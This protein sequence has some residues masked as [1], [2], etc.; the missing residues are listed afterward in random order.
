MRLGIQCGRDSDVPRY[1]PQVRLPE[2]SLTT[3]PKPPFFSAEKV[4]HSRVSI[5]DCSRQNC[6]DGGSMWGVAAA[7]AVITCS[8]CALFILPVASEHKVEAYIDVIK[9]VRS[10]TCNK[11]HAAVAAVFLDE[12]SLNDYEL[13]CNTDIIQILSKDFSDQNLAYS[14]IVRSDLEKHLARLR[15]DGRRICRF[16]SPYCFL[17]LS[18]HFELYDVQLERGSAPD[19]R[20]LKTISDAF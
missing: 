1:G 10:G 4:A 3:A 15:E 14:V 13:R 17:R 12:N 7:G 19:N 6:V 20:I 2:T 16:L 5:N 11:N 8:F 9:Q 18:I